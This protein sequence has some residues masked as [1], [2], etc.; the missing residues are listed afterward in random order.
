MDNLSN[1][2]ASAVEDA[3]CGADIFS[4]EPS[5]WHCLAGLRVWHRSTAGFHNSKT[6][7][8]ALWKSSGLIGE[9]RVN[10]VGEASGGAD[11]FSK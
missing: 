6:T 9:A 2:R 11:S 10:A 5:A 7:T 4:N 3:A 8:G 1:I